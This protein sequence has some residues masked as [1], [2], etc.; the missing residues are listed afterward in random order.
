MGE[1]VRV[2]VCVTVGART[3]A[4]ACSHVPLLI[5]HATRRR[6]ANRGLSG[7]TTVFDII[8][9]TARFSER[10][11]TENKTCFD[12]LYNFYLKRFSF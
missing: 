9:Q 12:F 8:S 11:I 1:Y 5:Q 4:C 10:K 6:I 3:R 2:P 7:S